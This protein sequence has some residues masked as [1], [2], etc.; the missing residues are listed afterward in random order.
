MSHLLRSMLFANSAVF[1]SGTQRVNGERRKFSQNQHQKFS[2]I[3]SS[4]YHWGV[5]VLMSSS[6]QK[7]LFAIAVNI[8][9]IGT[10]KMI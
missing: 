6:S 5:G 10:S 3:Q 7:P 2:F 1:V 4:R 8:L 9:K